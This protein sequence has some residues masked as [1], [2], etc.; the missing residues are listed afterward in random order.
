MYHGVLLV[1]R[2][3]DGLDV[4]LSAR[5]AARAGV[6]LHDGDRVEFAIAPGSAAVDVML[7]SYTGERHRT[8]PRALPAITILTRRPHGSRSSGAVLHYASDEPGH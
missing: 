6:A 1:H 2:D 4:Y 8:A 5:E 7:C 3:D